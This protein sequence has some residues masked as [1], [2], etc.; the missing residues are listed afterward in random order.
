[1]FLFSIYSAGELKTVK[2]GLTAGESKTVKCV[3]TAGESSIGIAT[4]STDCG[5][6]FAFYNSSVKRIFIGF[7]WSWIVLREIAR[8][9]TYLLYFSGFGFSSRDCTIENVFIGFSRIGFSSRDC[10][11]EN[12]F[13]GFSQSG[14]S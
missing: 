6:L 13:I 11:V 14:F 5:F 3:L 2:C 4:F 8:L 9:K 10:T 7:S 12:V 1:M